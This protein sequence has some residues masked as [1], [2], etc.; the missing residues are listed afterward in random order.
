M[1]ESDMRAGNAYHRVLFYAKVSTRDTYGASVDSWP[2]ITITTR[3]EIRYFGGSKT[4]SSEEKF[5]SKSMEL[6]VRYRSSI[7]ETMKVKIDGGTDFYVITYIEPIRRN[8]D[9]RITLEKENA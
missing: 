7:V 3:G 1:D 8:E 6:T 5:Y 2:A 4:L 9:L